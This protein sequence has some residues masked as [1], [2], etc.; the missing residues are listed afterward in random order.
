MFGILITVFIFVLIPKRLG[1]IT[2]NAINNSTTTDY[3]SLDTALKAIS[4]GKDDEFNA[5]EI[6]ISES[7]AITGSYVF[8]Q[9]TIRLSCA[10]QLCDLFFDLDGQLKLEDNSFLTLDGFSMEVFESIKSNAAFALGNNTSLDIK[11]SFGRGI[12]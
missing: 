10:S 8:K 11:V 5:F 9:L 1:F 6:K 4:L 12:S 7:T 3:T 2:I